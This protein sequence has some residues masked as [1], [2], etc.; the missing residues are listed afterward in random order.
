MAIQLKILIPVGI[1]MII[2]AAEK[3]ARESMSIPT[4]NMWWAHTINPSSPM[5]MIAYIIPNIPNVS[6][7]PVYRVRMWEIIPNPGIMRMYTSGCPKNQNRCWNR[8]GSPPPAGSKKELLKFRSV[9]IMVIPPASTGKDRRSR[10]VVVATAQMN[11]GTR[12]GVID[13]CFMFIMVA[14]KLT[15]PMI[16]EIPATCKEKIIKSTE[17][18]GWYGARERGG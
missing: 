12:S 9:R 13:L 16:E 6:F 11:R 7:F 15:D 14:R 8:M 3:Y 10:I 18:P 5:A 1:A 17:Y 2:V 4:V